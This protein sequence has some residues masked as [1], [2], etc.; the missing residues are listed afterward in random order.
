MFGVPS[1]ITMNPNQPSREQIEARI[2]ALLLGELPADESELLRWTISQ[3]AELQKLHGRL[4][5]TVGLV[6]EVVVAQICNLP[7]RRV[8]LGRTFACSIDFE[9]FNG[10][11]IAN[12]RYGRVQ[13]CATTEP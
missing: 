13:L 11:R 7:Y 6:R 9:N 12:P 8:A 3:D 1:P 4:L 5:L 2:T 10:Q